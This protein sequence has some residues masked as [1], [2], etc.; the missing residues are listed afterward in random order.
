MVAQAMIASGDD[1]K[2]FPRDLG[3]KLRLWLA[4]LPAS[5]GLATLRACVK[6]WYGV[7]PERIGV[8][9]AGNDPAM[10]A[11]IIGA[12]IDDREPLKRF[13][14]PITHTDPKAEHSSLAV[15]F[16]A[17][18]ACCEAT[19]RGDELLEKLRLLLGEAADLDE[20]LSL[21][22]RAVESVSRGDSTRRFAKQLGLAKGVSGYVYHTV[23]VA[24][25][26][27]L[28]LQQDF[29]LAIQSVVQCG[30]DTDSTAAIVGGIAGCHVQGGHS[31]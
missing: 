27:W 26:A 15:S 2:A 4:M 14:P 19:V 23:P 3:R 24:V 9:S 29:K 30:G 11:A 10:R 12:A 5:T 16:A 31:R 18:L 28:R 13:V 8:F 7:S 20:L 21:L 17:R 1:V 22:E 6:L 25:H